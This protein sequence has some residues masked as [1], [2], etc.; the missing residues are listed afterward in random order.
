MLQARCTSTFAPFLK[1]HPQIRNLL[2]FWGWATRLVLF[3]VD[4]DKRDECRPLLKLLHHLLWKSNDFLS[5]ADNVELRT[6]QYQT[7][8]LFLNRT[9]ISLI[10]SKCPIWVMQETCKRAGY[11]PWGC[12]LLGWG[13]RETEGDLEC[14]GTAADSALS[15]GKV[16]A[17]VVGPALS[18]A[19]EFTRPDLTLTFLNWKI[20]QLFHFCPPDLW[21]LKEAKLS[22]VQ[23]NIN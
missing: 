12:I 14:S 13:F 21:L 15:P 22:L 11:C 7:K 8:G 2:C 5:S 4:W 10:T 19:N 9:C 16:A 23:P 6:D 20:S 17:R 3:S 18:Y 1:V